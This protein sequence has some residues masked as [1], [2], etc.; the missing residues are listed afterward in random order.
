M[1][2]ARREPYKLGAHVAHRTRLDN[3][4]LGVP[5]CKIMK[6]ELQSTQ[7]NKSFRELLRN[8]YKCQNH[9]NVNSVRTTPARS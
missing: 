5:L 6:N 4:F 2:W 7:R 1:G 3:L 8:S 9:G